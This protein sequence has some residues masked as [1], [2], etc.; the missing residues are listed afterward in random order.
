MINIV[1]HK[2]YLSRLDPITNVHVPPCINK[3]CC[4]ST[5]TPAPTESPSLIESII[6]EPMIFEEPA[7]AGEPEEKVDHNV[8]YKAGAHIF[9]LVFDYRVFKS[10]PLLFFVLHTFFLAMG[11]YIPFIYTM[12]RCRI[13]NV[14][15]KTSKL[16]IPMIGVGNLIGRF[17]C[18]GLAHLTY[19]NPM[20]TMYMMLMV[21]GFAIMFSGLTFD[22]WYLYLTS[23][24]YGFGICEYYKYI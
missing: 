10:I 24:A 14:S 23:A 16:L 18:L 20:K 8:V 11:Y 3:P 12:D 13:N 7:I 9:G 2:F 15:S 22:V 6:K 17:F 19:I 4:C 1:Q 21:G 5:Q